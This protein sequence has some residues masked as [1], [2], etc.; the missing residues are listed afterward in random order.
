MCVRIVLQYFDIYISILL[1]D[2]SH[3]DIYT[4]GKHD[5]KENKILNIVLNKIT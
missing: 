5:K 1:S 3:K 2:T 4:T